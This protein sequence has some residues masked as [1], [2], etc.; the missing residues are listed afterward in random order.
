[1]GAVEGGTVG[2]VGGGLVVGQV[3]GRLTGDLAAAVKVGGV[4]MTPRPPILDLRHLRTRASVVING[5]SRR[6]NSKVGD[7]ASGPGWLVVPQLGIL[8]GS[9]GTHSS[10]RMTLT[11]AAVLGEVGDGVVIGIGGITGE[12][13]AEAVTMAMEDDRTTDLLGVVDGSR[14]R[15]VMAKGPAPELYTKAQGLDLPA[16]DE[17]REGA[18][19]KAEHER[20]LVGGQGMLL[21]SINSMYF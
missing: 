15:G 4:T 21:S 6:G 16:E 12:W 19:E 17:V 9:K 1:M 11:K 14:T 2:M 10:N 3:A 18:R 5:G 8:L 7:R 13:E 20:E